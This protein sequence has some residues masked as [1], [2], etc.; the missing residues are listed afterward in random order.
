[1]RKIIISLLI[2][3]LVAPLLGAQE[4]FSFASEFSSLSGGGMNEVRNSSEVA[5]YSMSSVS[6]IEAINNWE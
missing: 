6:P 4:R 5:N 3:F 1:M 2:L